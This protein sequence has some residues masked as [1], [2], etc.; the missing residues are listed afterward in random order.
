M[1]R[2]VRTSAALRIPTLAAFGLTA[3]A[4]ALLGTRVGEL[5]AFTVDDTFITLQ[6]AKH[7][8]QGY[9][10]V[11]N[12]GGP[13]AEGY[14][15]VLWMVILAFV[16]LLSGKGVLGAKLLSVVFAGLSVALAA[17][18]AYKGSVGTS[19]SARMFAACL[20]IAVAAS[21]WKL[22]VHAVTG[23]ET[24]LAA[25]LVAGFS[26]LALRVR[27]EG[28]RASLRAFF[29]L[30]LCCILARP[31][32]VLLVGVS[33]AVIYLQVDAPSRR[34]LLLQGALFLLLPGLGYF[35][36]RYAYFGLPFP[37]PFYVK[38]QGHGNFAGLPDVRA[39]F[40]DFVLSRPFLPALFFTGAALSARLI[41][42]PFLGAVALTLFFLFPSHIMGFEQRY[43]MPIL[44]VFLGLMG[45]GAAHT[46]DAIALRFKRP[47]LRFGL[48][49]V[50]SALLTAL[51]LSPFPEGYAA[52]RARWQAYGKGLATAHLALA[53]DL[54]QYQQKAERRVIALLDVG[55][56][57]YATNWTVIDTYGLNDARVALSRRGDVAH[58]FGQHPDLLVLVSKRA[59][60]FVAE[61]PW[62]VALAQA[63]AGED[64]VWVRSYPFEAD[65]HLALYA[66]AD[67]PLER[68]LR[69]R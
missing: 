18:F 23:M 30:G 2:D 63:A 55:V 50:V 47:R 20:P 53:R 31:E 11:W 42:A 60:T 16:E 40:A 57:A 34:A 64:F 67:T 49:V 65:Y 3:V 54:Q 69:P 13:P 26:T 5:W 12:I 51:S 19:R 44:P 9:G 41:V 28:D 56:V 37:L 43:L 7:L 38:A 59:D 29:V 35:A 68:A 66:R 27:A 46:F 52:S 61:Y 58:V 36:A 1:A 32:T 25:A 17:R 39:F 4:G 14:T 62:E 45:V 10:P 33:L 22:A 48:E 24:T 6:Y 21:Y 15:A 8:A